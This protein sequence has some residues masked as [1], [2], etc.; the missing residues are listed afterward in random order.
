MAIIAK[1]IRMIVRLPNSI[2]W[3]VRVARSFLHF[4]ARSRPGGR[5]LR[6]EALSNVTSE[7]EVFT[8]ALTIMTDSDRSDHTATAF[9]RVIAARSTDE[10][11]SFHRSFCVREML[12]WRQV[13]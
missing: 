13:L 5:W 1:T 12:K 10:S 3:A 9:C 7:V 11:R 2:L 4:Q 8:K 6:L